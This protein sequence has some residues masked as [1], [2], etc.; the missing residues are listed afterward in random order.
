LNKS[1]KP[2]DN[3]SKSLEAVGLGNQESTKEKGEVDDKESSIQAAINQV[4]ESGI[5]EASGEGID[6]VA[7]EPVDLQQFL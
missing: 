5:P 2:D 1:S 3:T 4:D 7:K 6:D